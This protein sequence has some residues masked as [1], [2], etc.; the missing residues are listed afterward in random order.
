MAR[1]RVKELI[2]RLETLLGVWPEEEE[3][4]IAFLDSIKNEFEV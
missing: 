2:A 3:T 1:E 4:I